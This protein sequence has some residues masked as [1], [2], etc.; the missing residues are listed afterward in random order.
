[1]TRVLANVG[2]VGFAD[3]AVVGFRRVGRAHQAAVARHGIIG[4]ERGHDHG[5]AR[6]ELDELAEER[7][8]LVNLIEALGLRATQ[9]KHAHAQ[10]LKACALNHGDDVP[11]VVLLDGV[12]LDNA[13]GA[14]D[15]H[16]GSSFRCCF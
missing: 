4:L 13:Q 11:D 12:G 6:H 1:V 9:V 7:S 16:V 15:S 10:D 5:P 8:F 3:G 2:A 14:F